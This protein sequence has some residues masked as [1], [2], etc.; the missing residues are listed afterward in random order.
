M[1]CSV[2]WRSVTEFSGQHIRNVGNYLLI[3]AAYYSGGEK[4]LFKSRRKPE[5]AQ[6]FFFLSK[7]SPLCFVRSIYRM[8]CTIMKLCSHTQLS[9]Y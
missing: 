4:I 7:A 1:L 5:I 9:I 6:N 2:D 3:W 8:W